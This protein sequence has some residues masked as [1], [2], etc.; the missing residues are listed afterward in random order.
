MASFLPLVV[1]GCVDMDPNPIAEQ[2]AAR[3]FFFQT[4][5][6]RCVVVSIVVVSMTG[7]KVKR[8]QR[9]DILRF[10]ADAR[11]LIFGSIGTPLTT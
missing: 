10:R 5:A 3:F 2:R 7:K 8:R 4:Q 6:K 11:K 9:K 1:N